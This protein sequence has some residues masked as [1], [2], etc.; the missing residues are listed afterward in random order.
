[1]IVDSMLL[2]NTENLGSSFPYYIEY[3]AFTF[4]NKLIYCIT[5]FL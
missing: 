1:M 4:L 5:V 3:N 2:S